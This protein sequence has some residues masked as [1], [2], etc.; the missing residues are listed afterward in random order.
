MEHNRFDDQED[1]EFD[2]DIPEED[3][4]EPQEKTYPS[5]VGAGFWLQAIHV[6]QRWAA[7]FCQVVQGVL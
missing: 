3:Y 6:P 7:Q 4:F 1:L 5:I 2:L